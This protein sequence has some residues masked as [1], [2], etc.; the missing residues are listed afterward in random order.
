MSYR[1]PAYVC[2]ECK[3]KVASIQPKPTVPQLKMVYAVRLVFW[4]FAFGVVSV[5]ADN[6][7]LV[8]HTVYEGAVVMLG[9][10]QAVGGI[11]VAFIVGN[12]IDGLG[13]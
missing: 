10:L 13:N 9:I 8:H 11:V 7:L 6:H 1:E 12:Y 2:D 5:F 3:N 4:L